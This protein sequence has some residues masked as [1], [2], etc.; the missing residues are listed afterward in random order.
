M[1]GVVGIWMP[2][3]MPS[4]SESLLEVVRR[5]TSAIAHRGP[6]GEGMWSDVGA[7]LYL[8]HRRLAILD[9]TAAGR[10]PMVATSGRYV[11]VVNGEI[12][13]FRALRSELAAAGSVFR[14]NGDTEVALAAIERW[15]VRPAVERFIGMFAIGLW[16]KEARELWLVRDRLG[17]K[18]L[19]FKHD[20]AGVAFG[21][22][23]RALGEALGS[24]AAVDRQAVA[25]FLRYGFVPG[26]RS[27]LTNVAKLRPGTVA[28]FRLDAAGT[29]EMDEQSYWSVRRVYAEK[30]AEPR[31]ES[32]DAAAEKLGSLLT[33]AVRL[34]LESDVPLGAFLSGGIDSTTVVALM[35]RLTSRRVRTFTV[36]FQESEFDEASSARAVANYLGTEHT[37]VYVDEKE[38]IALI[39]E[40]PKTYDEP[41]ADSSQLPTLLVSQMAR[42]HVTVAL[43]G[44]GGDEVFG[45][46]RRYQRFAQIWRWMR[47]ASPRVRMTLAAVF[48]RAASGPVFQVLRLADRFALGDPGSVTLRQQFAKLAALLRLSGMDAVYERQL[49][50][51]YEPRE[52]VPD[53][54]PP[55]C[56]VALLAPGL[57]ASL[58]ECFERMMETDLCNYLPDDILVKV[59][60]ATMRVGLEARAPLLDH[61]IVE[62]AAGL[63]VAVRVTSKQGKRVLRELASQLVPSALIDRPK[64]GFGVPLAAWLR[65]P[66]REWAGDTLNAESLRRTGLVR[67]G[68]IAR[69]WNE[70]LRG[71]SDWSAQLWDVLMLEAW[72]KEYLGQWRGTT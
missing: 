67:A 22:E 54:Q 49:A 56:D 68:P 26:A 62:F 17:K 44:D 24:A 36:G 21:S 5:M 37:E 46:Y 71:E 32:L 41:F 35:Q 53:A 45:G 50:H 60:R 7:G 61:R 30:R 57:D 14:G 47:M 18:P 34:R 40:M 11:I 42:R 1:C 59:D 70:H 9:L 3:G 51:W 23:L 65:G 15:G 13:N 38:L 25:Q 48:D 28:R 63:P 69:C 64:Q 10:Q 12:Y 27:I 29:V 4:G 43:S 2:A 72:H 58:D 20:G 8:G 31:A 19:Y 33:D 66:L 6:D 39:P 16:D 55:W 52:L